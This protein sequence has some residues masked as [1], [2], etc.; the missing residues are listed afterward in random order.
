MNVRRLIIG[1]SLTIGLLCS[2][3]AAQAQTAGGSCTLRDG[4]CYSDIAEGA[5]QDAQGTFSPGHTCSLKFTPNVPIPGLFSKT[6]DVD[7]SLFSRYIGAFYI[8]FAGVAGIVAVVVM[9]WGGFHYITSAGNAQKMSQGRE[10]INNAII[11]LIL[12]FTSYLLLNLI[13]PN[14]TRLS[15]P[16]LSVLPQIV[17][18]ALYCEAGGAGS[19]QMLAAAAQNA[20]C[21]A[22]VEFTTADNIKETCISLAV[23]PDEQTRDIACVPVEVVVDGKSTIQYQRKSAVSACEDNRYTEDTACSSTQS[24]MA[25]QSWL[26]GGC[27]KADIVGAVFTGK[28][29]CRYFPY[30]SCLSDYARVS[31]SAAGRLADSPCWDNENPRVYSTPDRIR[32]HCVDPR[33]V[34][35]PVE[36]IDGICCQRTKKDN[37]YCVNDACKNDEVEVSCTQYNNDTS[38]QFAT[39]PL[40]LPGPYTC[41]TTGTRCCAQIIMMYGNG[42]IAN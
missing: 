42:D 41:G 22:E 31:C 26:K 37:V 25:V 35:R 27:K 39:R 10:I 11:G 1:I 29:V 36:R 12:L 4:R 30:Y 17:Q 20:R 16:S 15:L 18:P 34:P 7:N 23:D 21:G 38:R 3:V 19:P 2:T 8:F 6:V 28:D 13:N 24:V 5:C 9:M 40:G 14:L 33:G 32:A